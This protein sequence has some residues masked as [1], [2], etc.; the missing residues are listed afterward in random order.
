M[1]WVPKG[2]THS[3]TKQILEDQVSETRNKEELQSLLRRWVKLLKE[4]RI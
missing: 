4:S 2:D 1:I 3:K